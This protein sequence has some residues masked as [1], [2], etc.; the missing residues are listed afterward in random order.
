[1]YIHPLSDLY[2]LIKNVYIFYDVVIDSIV[3]KTPQTNA[4]AL[5]RYVCMYACM[6]VGILSPIPTYIYICIWGLSICG[7]A[8]SWTVDRKVDVCGDRRLPIS[9][10]LYLGFGGTAATQLNIDGT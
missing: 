6:Y 5:Y 4:C 10:E 7:G 2:L 3:K 9:R 8:L 1:M